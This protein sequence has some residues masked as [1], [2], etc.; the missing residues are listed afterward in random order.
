ML[1]VSVVACMLRE[2]WH[3]DRDLG[4][5][6]NQNW[7]QHSSWKFGIKIKTVISISILVIRVRKKVWSWGLEIYHFT[8]KHWRKCKV[9]FHDHDQYKNPSRV[10][11]TLCCWACNNIAFNPFREEIWPSHGCMTD[12]SIK[13]IAVRVFTSEKKK[14]KEREMEPV[15]CCE[16]RPWD[17]RL[18][19]NSN[20]FDSAG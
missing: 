3:F 16:V 10:R 1:F 9:L 11:T 19:I 2:S 8:C 5:M 13:Q 4:R 15:I 20:A 7:E 6:G 18:Y 17:S 12:S 14:E